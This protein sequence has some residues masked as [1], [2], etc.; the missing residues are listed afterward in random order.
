LAGKILKFLREHDNMRLNR[1]MIFVKNLDRMVAFYSGTLGLKAIEETRLDNFVEF[2][3]GGTKFALHAI[4]R[5]IAG[6]IEISSPPTPREKCPLKLT[7]EVEDAELKRLQELGL[8]I[9][10][11][12]WGACDAVDPEGNVFGIE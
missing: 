5:E 11:R 1:A 2:D 3:A 6:Q 4:P 9:I 8:T 12:P 7:F 10:E